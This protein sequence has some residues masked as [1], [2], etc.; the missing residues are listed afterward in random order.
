[1]VFQVWDWDTT[2]NTYELTQYLLLHREDGIEAVS[3]EARVRAV[4]RPS[5]SA[6]LEAAGLEGV[7]WFEPEHS[8]FYQPIVAARL[9]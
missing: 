2:G 9:P 7:Q 1:V 5:L 6:A 4:T 8:G 3:F